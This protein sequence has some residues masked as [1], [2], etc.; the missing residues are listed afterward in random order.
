MG[1]FYYTEQKGDTAGEDKVKAGECDSVVGDR[2]KA[3]NTFRE[4]VVFNK[5][6]IYPEYIVFVS[7]LHAADDEAQ[8]RER[9]KIAFQ[10]Q[11]PV[12]W[13][14]CHLDPFKD[15]FHEQYPVRQKT[16]VFLR[17]LLSD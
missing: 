17:R 13:T 8:M 10:A 4:L 1:K 2:A 3:A 11:L 12:Y 9:A 14:N 15:N 7:R 6:Q 5:D 16:M